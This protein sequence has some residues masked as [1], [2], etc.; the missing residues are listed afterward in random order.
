MHDT[1]GNPTAAYLWRDVIPHVQGVARCV[2]PDLI[3]QGH[4][5]KEPRNQYRFRDHYKY[6][7]EWIDKM[8]YRSL[9]SCV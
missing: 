4:S 2:A 1:P 9:A 7:S 3:G 5:G 8:R 6:L